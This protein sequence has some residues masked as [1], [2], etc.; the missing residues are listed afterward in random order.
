MKLV[1][2][3]S[4]E[5]IC[6]DDNSL[7]YVTAKWLPQ[8]S[9]LNFLDC[10]RDDSCSLNN[11]STGKYLSIPFL[12]DLKEN[13]TNLMYPGID[14]LTNLCPDIVFSNFPS[15]APQILSNLSAAV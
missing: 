3:L 5:I 10:P 12:G 6:R 11:L 9:P 4:H 8:D 14:S 13:N 15:Y 2:R 1:G 7:S